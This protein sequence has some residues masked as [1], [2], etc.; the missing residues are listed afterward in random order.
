MIE[1]RI[2]R[3]PGRRIPERRIN[4]NWLIIHDHTPRLE[5]K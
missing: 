1:G 2:I 3:V 4:G 5:A